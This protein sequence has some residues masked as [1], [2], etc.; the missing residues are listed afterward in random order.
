[1]TIETLL[2]INGDVLINAGFCC[3]NLKERDSVENKKVD[4]G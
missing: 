2:G 1:M 4:A 3:R